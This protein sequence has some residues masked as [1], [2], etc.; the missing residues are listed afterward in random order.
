M[1]TRLVTIHVRMSVAERDAIKHDAAS[2]GIGASSW[3]RSILCYKNPA[4]IS[5]LQSRPKPLEVPA[6]DS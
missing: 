4:M 6:D 1:S 2:V 5:H 3:V